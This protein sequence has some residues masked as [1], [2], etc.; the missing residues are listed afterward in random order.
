[1]TNSVNVS[2]RCSKSVLSGPGSRL[3]HQDHL[4]LLHQRGPGI[5]S[6]ILLYQ[7]VNRMRQADNLI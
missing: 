5:R 3:V 1:M 4:R 2:G 6:L 7:P